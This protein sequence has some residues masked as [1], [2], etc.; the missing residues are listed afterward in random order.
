MK[1]ATAG[2]TIIGSRKNDGQEATAP[3]LAQEE[4]REDEAE[5]ELDADRDHGEDDGAPDGAQ[6]PP[7][8]SASQ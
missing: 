4:E 2:T 1:P 6:K 3:E 8:E 5:R 7:L